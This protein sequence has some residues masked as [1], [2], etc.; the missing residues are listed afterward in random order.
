MYKKIGCPCTSTCVV[1]RNSGKVRYFNHSI[2]H[3]FQVRTQW[4][5]FSVSIKSRLKS[6]RHMSLYV[7]DKNSSAHYVGVKYLFGKKVH[8][9]E[10]AKE[11]NLTN[12]KISIKNKKV[13]AL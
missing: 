11:R 10:L 3:L 8:M 5:V 2:R 6:C 4:S 7:Q 9:K 1:R 12:L 13:L